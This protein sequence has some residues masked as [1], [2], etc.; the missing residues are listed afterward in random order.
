MKIKEIETVLGAEIVTG[1]DLTDTEIQTAFAS[2][3]M[4]DVLT[5]VEGK[6]VLLT[7]LLNPQVI[8]TAEMLDI[9]AVVFVRGKLPSQE[10]INMAKKN[11]I[12]ILT[13]PL[14]LFTASGKLYGNGLRGVPIKGDDING[15]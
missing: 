8:R 14:T 3:L 13:T 2:D 11:N 7:G 12:A 6:S 1:D 5:Y 9:L 10:I 15:Q 4:S